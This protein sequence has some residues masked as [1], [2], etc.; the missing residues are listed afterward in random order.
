MKR[1]LNYILLFALTNLLTSASLALTG[2]NDLILSRAGHGEVR[3]IY[4]TGD[5]YIVS[6]GDDV[7]KKYGIGDKSIIGKCKGDYYIISS[8]D[9][10][11]FDLRINSI[12]EKPGLKIT[13]SQ[14]DRDEV[15]K[16]RLKVVK[17]PEESMVIRQE[18]TVSDQRTYGIKGSNAD[19]TTMTEM[20]S[21][22][23]LESYISKLQDMDTRFFYA[24][25]RR[26]VAVWIRDKF[27]ELG[28][29]TAYLDSF[30]L[31]AFSSWLGSFQGTWQYNV[32]AEIPGA[33]SNDEIVIIGGHHDSIATQSGENSMIKAPGA[34]DN[35]TAVAT[36]LEIARVYSQYGFTPRNRLK[37]ITFAAE[38]IG[39]RGS[40]SYASRAHNSGMDIKAMINV[41][42]T[43]Y[44]TSSNVQGAPIY[45]IPY[46]NA[47]DLRDLAVSAGNSYSSLSP[48][49]STAGWQSS[50]DS[51][52]FFHYGFKPVWF[53]EYDF[54]PY[55]H[56]YND[57]LANMNMDY[58]HESV[59]AVMA[60]G[61]YI[62]EIPDHPENYTLRDRGDGSSLLAQWDA[63]DIADLEGYKIYLGEASGQYGTFYTSETNSFILDGLE[64]GVE[65]FAGI[66]VLLKNGYESSIVEKQAVPRSVPL[67]PEGL[68]AEPLKMAIKLFW[69]SNQETDIAGYNIYK[70]AGEGYFL[71]ISLDKQAT[72]YEDTEVLSGI[73]NFYRISAFDVNGN[74]SEK[75]EAVSAFPLTFDQGILIVNESPNGTGTASDPTAE[76]VSEYFSYL[77][78]DF[79]HVIYFTEQD[80]PVRINELGLY[81]MVVWNTRRVQ[82][83]ESIFR[84]SRVEIEKYLDY[85][86][87][88]LIN[89]DKTGLLS[90]NNLAYPHRTAEDSFARNYLGVDSLYFTS[91]SRFNE[92]LSQVSEYGSIGLDSSKVVP[93]NGEYFLRGIEA[94]IPVHGSQIIYTYGSKYEEGSNLAL[95][96]FKPIGLKKETDHFK[97]ALL[98]FHLYYADQIQAK[99][100]FRSIILDFFGEETG[101]LTE[102]EVIKNPDFKLYQNYP[103]PFNPVTRISFWLNSEENIRL[104]VFDISGKEIS[105]LAEGIY[106]EGQHSIK[107]DA[108]G[109]SAGLYIYRL[110]TGKGIL[111]RKLV[112]V[113]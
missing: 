63:V 86:G 17:V 64:E 7:L 46:S 37:L 32:V 33:V 6:A 22:D 82:F 57:V 89:S 8:A 111:S 71:K 93:S 92:A 14:P 97:T 58:F 59:K 55:Y 51:Y 90:E 15:V 85:G 47:H 66:S 102:H 107:Y 20:V 68:E 60:T 94:V 75:S 101:M 83:G 1:I 78:S 30:Y 16:Y 21:K 69:N 27:L 52:A 53:F 99:E 19:L 104:S 91:I 9:G 87:K 26:D 29:E 24:P 95:L 70:D 41:D 67:S 45:V 80:T 31:P 38:E 79:D 103:N 106:K 113:K 62:M 48:L 112:L 110:Q 39:L 100:F 74:E 84:Q 36:A 98:N 77:A 65:Y 18:A 44:S 5:E 49:V 81:S 25:N 43:G 42:M 12:Y 34:D 2:R 109:L 11:P 3:I 10:K 73:E 96:K 76:M 50:S 23:S 54:N 40:Y 13:A 28:V 35:A 4:F 72:E 56:S 105:V 108:S 61:F 88:L